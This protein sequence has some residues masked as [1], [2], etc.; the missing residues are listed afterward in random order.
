MENHTPLLNITIRG[1]APGTSSNAA[2]SKK[3]NLREKLRTGIGDD[4]LSC[5]KRCKNA[6]KLSLKACFY[7]D[8]HGNDYIRQ[9]LD[10]LLKILLDVLQD[11]MDKQRK[12]KGLGI[13]SNDEQVYHVGCTKK[14][15]SNEDEEGIDVELS[16][17]CQLDSA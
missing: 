6:G 4:L 10:N 8:A 16:S 13:I 11:H 7:L 15:V 14:E 17:F 9:D 5:Q 2:M 3:I 1:F 12:H